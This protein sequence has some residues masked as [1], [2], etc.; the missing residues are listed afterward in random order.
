M[1]L[2][3]GEVGNGGDGQLPAFTHCWGIIE[4]GGFR[5]LRPG[6]PSP[7]P[8]APGSHLGCQHRLSCGVGSDYSL[9]PRSL[10]VGGQ[11]SWAASGDETYHASRSMELFSSPPPAPQT[12]FLSWGL[13]VRQEGAPAAPAWGSLPKKMPLLLLLM[14]FL[15]PPGTG[16]G[17]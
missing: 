5:V 9:P 3:P 10:A 13:Q 14:A 2:Y 15:L 6:T 16:A 12:S 4:F 17:E 8:I 7:F 11:A 1:R